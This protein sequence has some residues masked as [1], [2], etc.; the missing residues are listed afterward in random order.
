MIIRHMFSILSCVK[1]SVITFTLT[2]NKG[3]S[4]CQKKEYICKWLI[5]RMVIVMMNNVHV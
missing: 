2:P 1:E 4:A 3:Q 5:N